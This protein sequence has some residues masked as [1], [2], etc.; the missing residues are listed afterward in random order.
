MWCGFVLGELLKIPDELFM[1]QDGL[2]DGLEIQEVLV[3]ELSLLPSIFLLPELLVNIKQ[4][5]VV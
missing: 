3:A 1:D 2:L 4:T 5:K